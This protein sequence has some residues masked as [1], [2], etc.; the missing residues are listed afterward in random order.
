MS[1]QIDPAN[2]DQLRAWDTGEGVFWAE[3][4]D[5]F[6]HALH[7]YDEALLRQ[8]GI[9]D[10]D[11]VLD[12]GCGT[13]SVTEAAVRLAGSGT[14]LGVDLS[15]PMLAIAALSAAGSE[16]LAYVQADAQVH[17]FA[18]GEFDV[19]LSRTGTMFFADQVA[20]F[21]NLRRAT[22]PGGR[23][24]LLSWRSAAENE[25]FLSLTTALRAGRE[26]PS[27]PPG[28][29]GPFSQAD[30][31]AVA[32]VLTEAGFAKPGFEALDEPMYFGPDVPAAEQFVLGV[33]GWLLVGLDDETRTR[34]LE[35]LRA[36][37]E[38]HQTAGGVAYASSA[39]L[40]GSR[41]V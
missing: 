24:A 8:A 30:P 38:A 6:E 7:R 27:P 32:E 17:P 22:R 18:D 33:L 15:S 9:Q 5:L 10:G 40:I 11:R 28:A 25:W 26:L 20:A 29:P 31:S 36:D 37:L 3:E 21:K 2:A 23:L 14:A 1:V 13:G 34:A 4:A 39:W 19:V 41:A 16:N 12:V 35:A